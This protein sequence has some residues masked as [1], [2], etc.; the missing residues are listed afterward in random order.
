MKCC[1]SRLVVF[2][3]AVILYITTNTFMLL[4][5]LEIC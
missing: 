2:D 4:D 1:A 5:E 3:T